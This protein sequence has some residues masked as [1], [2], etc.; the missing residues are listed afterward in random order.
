MQNSPRL[1]VES[2][3]TAEQLKGQQAGKDRGIWKG[4]HRIIPFLFKL[5]KLKM[6]FSALHSLSSVMHFARNATQTP[7]HKRNSLV[8]GSHFRGVAGW[9]QGPPRHPTGLAH[10]LMGPSSL[11]VS[12][13]FG[14]NAQPGPASTELLQLKSRKTKKMGIL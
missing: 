7:W 13:L 5:K 10:S 8:A 6:G 12:T 11:T 3:E 14:L 4:G 1:W 2:W 9:L